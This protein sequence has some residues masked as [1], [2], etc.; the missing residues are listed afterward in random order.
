MEKAGLPAR[1]KVPCCTVKNDIIFLVCCGVRIGAD[2]MRFS[3]K[4]MS[5]ENIERDQEGLKDRKSPRP[6]FSG[7]DRIKNS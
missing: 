6:V 5:D 3:F 4:L 7:V 2:S 1:R